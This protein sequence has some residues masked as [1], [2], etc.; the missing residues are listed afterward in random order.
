MA[1]RCRVARSFSIA[2]AKNQLSKLVHDAEG[3]APIELTRRGE[4]VAV[5]LSVSDYKRL[6]ADKA[7]FWERF[8]QFRTDHRVDQLGIEPDVWLGGVRSASRSRD[9]GW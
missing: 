2:E 7:A 5:L 6:T 8:A 4:P 9:F 3:G 1:M